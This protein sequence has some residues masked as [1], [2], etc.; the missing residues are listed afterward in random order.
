MRP[1]K[2]PLTVEQGRA[3]A[4]RARVYRAFE[5]VGIVVSG[6]AIPAFALS[7]LELRDIDVTVL[8]GG[9]SRV[10]LFAWAAILVFVIGTALALLMRHLV[11][12]IARALEAEQ[13]RRWVEGEAPVREAT[14]GAAD[15]ALSA[16]A[17][18]PEGY[19]PPAAAG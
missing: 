9:E 14:G 8:A 16:R 1:P 17:R 12:R 2:G 5:W 7:Y 3:M 18:V 4:T 13:R 10:P 11:V 15:P 19:E 6:M